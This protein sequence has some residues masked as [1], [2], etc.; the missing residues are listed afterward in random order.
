MPGVRRLFR[1]PLTEKTVEREI[2]EELEFHVEAA[3]EDLV[4]RGLTRAEARERAMQEFGDLAGA[5]EELSEIDR[6]ALRRE[7]RSDRLDGLRQ[8]AGFAWRMLRKSPGF[9]ATAIA[10]LGL[11]I[12]ANVAIF[13][14]VDAALFR[15][16]PYP[17][18]E[19]LAAVGF[20]GERPDDSL[21]DVD[22][23]TYRAWAHRSHAVEALGT[24]TI[25]GYD[26]QG[27]AEPSRV[28]ALAVTSSLLPLLGVVPALG[29]G[30][31][32]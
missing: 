5:R 31:T 26:V 13:T 32:A 20:A 14:V 11:A 8:D 23:A 29:R 4:A 21:S 9:A 3:I 15:P 30:F 1:L 27:G 2:D 28:Q 12:G 24:Y 6:R 7:R 10:T 22:Y 19:E 18:S 25:E 16:L 17:S